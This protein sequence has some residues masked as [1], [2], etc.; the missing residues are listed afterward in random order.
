MMNTVMFI[1]LVAVAEL[2]VVWLAYSLGRDAGWLAG[3]E[4]GK[5]DHR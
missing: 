4:D 1:A 2:A 3:W 5:T